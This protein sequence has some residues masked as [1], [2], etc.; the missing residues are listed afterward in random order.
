MLWSLF[1]LCHSSGEG[2]SV[3]FLCH[4]QQ[5]VIGFLKGLICFKEGELD[6]ESELVS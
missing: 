3:H 4:V 5:A 1:L 6:S 2:A